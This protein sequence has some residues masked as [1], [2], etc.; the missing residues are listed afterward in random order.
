[1]S[2]SLDVQVARVVE[3]MRIIAKDLDSAAISRIAQYEKTEQLILSMALLD[4]RV[5]SIEQSVAAAAPTLVEFTAMKHKV[6]GAGILGR[7]IWLGAGA[8]IGLFIN[9]KGLIPWISK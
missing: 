6:Q 2:D 4:S 8:L 9:I 7:W 3:G 5:K 1:M